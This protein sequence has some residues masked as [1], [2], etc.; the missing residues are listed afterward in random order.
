MIRANSPSDKITRWSL[1]L[2]KIY[3]GDDPDLFKGERR[4]GAHAVYCPSRA[5]ALINFFKKIHIS[6]ILIFQ[7]LNA[8]CTSY[9]YVALFI[10]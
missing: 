3:Y 9:I 1:F 2:C 10:L 7:G 5:L 8:A 6:I 4:A